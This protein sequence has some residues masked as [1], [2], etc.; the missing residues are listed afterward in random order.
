MNTSN[1]SYTY[2][3]TQYT[4]TLIRYSLLSRLLCPYKIINNTIYQQI[5]KIDESSS[6]REMAIKSNNNNIGNNNYEKKSTSSP[7]Q[8]MLLL[9]VSVACLAFIYTLS[10]T[11][12]HTYANTH[13]AKRAAKEQSEN[14]TIPNA[15]RQHHVIVLMPIF[16]ARCFCTLVA[17]F[18]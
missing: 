8:Q 17:I 7:S 11:Q 4:Y 12:T 15:L 18:I 16:C 10:H 6:I 5:N 3:H 1:C 9:C 13:T 14:K 2:I